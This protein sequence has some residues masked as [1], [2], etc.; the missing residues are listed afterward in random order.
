MK[1]KIL[2]IIATA[3]IIPTWMFVFMLGVKTLFL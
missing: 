3:I 2:Y 1:K